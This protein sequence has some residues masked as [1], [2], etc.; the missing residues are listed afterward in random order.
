[1]NSS[2][3]AENIYRVKFDEDCW[4]VDGMIDL[5]FDEELLQAYKVKITKQKSA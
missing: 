4:V 1:M 2:V 5:G 3:D